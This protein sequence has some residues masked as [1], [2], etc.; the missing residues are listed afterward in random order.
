VESRA[1]QLEAQG[2]TNEASALY[3]ELNAIPQRP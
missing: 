1:R 3:R 2:K